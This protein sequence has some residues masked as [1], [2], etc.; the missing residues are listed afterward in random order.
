MDGG[1]GEGTAPLDAAPQVPTGVGAGA[2]GLAGSPSD[3]ISLALDTVSGL[4]IPR[5]YVVRD[6]WISSCLYHIFESGSSMDMRAYKEVDGESQESAICIFT[7]GTA[8]V[9]AWDITERY[10]DDLD[11]LAGSLSTDISREARRKARSEFS[12]WIAH[13][14]GFTDQDVELH[15]SRTSD[16]R[17]MRLP[18][19]GESRY[20]KVEIVS[21]DVEHDL[22]EQRPI[23]SLMGRF[24]SDHQRSQY[25]ELGG[26]NLPCTVPAYTATNKLDA[27]HRRAAK[28]DFGSLGTRVRDLYD[29]ARIAASEYGDAARAQIPAHAERASRSFGRGS[30]A[31][32]RPA[33][34]YAA[35][36]IFRDGS[37]AQ[38]A[39]K[40]AYPRLAAFVWGDLPPFD[41]ALELAASLD[42]QR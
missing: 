37:K 17:Q 14:L 7:G 16:Y 36:L 33:S 29:L 15:D 4:G 39:L 2:R 28:G 31:V 3:F 8:L 30:D 35:S 41:E 24:A 42:D 23:I 25:P 9:A 21:E 11:I 1:D 32:P 19:G 18:I 27:L 5:D 20:L 6:Y 22:Y 40:E 26:F 38:K 34:G 12:K 13:P 10:S